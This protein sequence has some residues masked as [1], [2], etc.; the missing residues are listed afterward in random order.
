MPRQFE[1]RV[2]CLLHNTHP[3]PGPLRLLHPSTLQN[4]LF[5]HWL[6]L[7]TSIKLSGWLFNII[8]FTVYKLWWDGGLDIKYKETW[9]LP[10]WYQTPARPLQ[11]MF[12]WVSQHQ[13]WSWEML[14][15][16]LLLGT[17]SLYSE[18]LYQG[19]TSTCTALISNSYK[20]FSKTS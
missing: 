15:L 19:L 6:P 4:S 14:A 3:G 7:K 18:Y 17:S 8:I 11:D 9:W 12:H 5:W 10:S 20:Y 16:L 1:L 13:Q 2:G